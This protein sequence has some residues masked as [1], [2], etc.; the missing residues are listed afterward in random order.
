MPGVPESLNAITLGVRDMGAAF[1][2]Y[3]DAGFRLH[4]GGRDSGFTT[5]AAGDTYVN[6]QSMDE[7]DTNWGRA[8]FHVDDV[9]AMHDRLVAAGYTPEF[10]PLD[11]PWGERYFHVLDPDGHE[12]S[13]ARRLDAP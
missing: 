12:I 11:A 8:I 6:L 2:F 1:A 7:P 9:D 3:H 5:F 10:E 13:F 4:Y